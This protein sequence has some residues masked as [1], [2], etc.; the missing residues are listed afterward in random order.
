METLPFRL[1]KCLHASSNSEVHATSD[2]TIIAKVLQKRHAHDV[3]YIKQELAFQRAVRHRAILPVLRVWDCDNH[4]VIGLPA[5]K[6]C[7]IDVMNDAPSDID[8]LLFVNLAQ[9]IANGLAA[10]H[11]N[12][13]LHGDVKLD[14]ILIRETT[15][16]PQNRFSRW[17]AVIA[18]FGA[19]T[20]LTPTIHTDAL[21]GTPDY[22]PPEAQ[23]AQVIPAAPVDIWAFGIIVYCMVNG[24][25]PFKGKF[26]PAM[27]RR[28]ATE[29]PLP[30][31]KHVPQQLRDVIDGCLARNPEERWSWPR[32]L[33]VLSSV[34]AQLC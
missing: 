22:Y 34:E 30:H 31:K 16:H 25:F 33:Y 32:I 10:L 27:R 15:G 21:F 9:D 17:E 23:H 18:D 8:L 19:A 12:G 26:G 2:P 3:F 24:R 6:A 20:A 4:I 11:R 7:L 5:M 13:I 1:V 29:A 14:N 28:I